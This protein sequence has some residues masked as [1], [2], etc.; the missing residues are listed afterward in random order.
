[1]R[2]L[3]DILELLVLAYFLLVNGFYSLVMVA[4]HFQL[5]RSRRE[6]QWESRD[7]IAG[8]KICPRIS[9]LSPAHN[10]E[11]SI[12]ESVQALLHHHY[13]SLEVVVIDDGSTDAT[14][15]KLIEAFRLNPV[16]PLLPPFL[17]TR[18]LLGLYTSE[19]HPNL[20]VASKANGGKSDALNMG[21]LL[22]GGD[23][24]CVV[25]ADTLLEADALQKLVR[26]FL[27]SDRVVAAG[28][29]LRVVNESRIEHAQVVEVRT[30]RH[31]LAGVQTVEYI[32]AFL[33]GRLGL[34]GLGGNLII[35]GAFGLFRRQQVLD[36][37][38]YSTTTVGED[39]EL[40]IRLRRRGMETGL[41]SVVEF[42][43]DPVAW[44]EA[45][46]TLKIL[47]SQRNRWQRG[48]CDSLWRHRQIL[49]NPAYG[50]MGMVAFPYQVLIELISPLV[51]SVG[52]ITLLLAILMGEL[53]LTYG[54][55]FF[56]AAYGWGTLLTAVGIWLEQRCFPAQ[57]RPGQQLWLIWWALVESLGYRQWAMVAR[58]Q[59]MGKWLLGHHEWGRMERVGFGR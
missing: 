30:P 26:P 21:L 47:R 6:S 17:E 2:D 39:M 33:F 34:N 50:S 42:V 3:V 37:G 10:E 23:L 54:L 38:G 27:S 19:R 31:W 51:E 59:G 25:D 1:M 22:S 11:A 24:C 9:I 53:N 57:R 32:R 4:A 52:W 12:V 29:T 45:P 15:Q 7:T 43:P 55:G 46:S 56:L 20:V 8:A 41:P 58:L 49:F 28:G 18:P 44:T 40:V 48:L 13:P 5:Q 16:V 35:S 36:C 14:L